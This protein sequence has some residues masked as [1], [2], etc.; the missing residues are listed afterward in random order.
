VVKVIVPAKVGVAELIPISKSTIK[1][2]S[3]L[4]IASEPDSSGR[5]V[6]REVVVFP[7]AARGTGEGS[8]P[9]DLPSKS[10]GHSRMT[11][12]TVTSSSAGAGHSKMTNGTVSASSVTGVTLTYH[13][14]SGSG[15]QSIVLPDTIPYVTF[16]PGSLKDLIVGAH[17]FVI[18]IKNSTN[19]NAVR[20]LVG[21]NGLVPPM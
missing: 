1:P 7:A 18:G 5:Q 19:F 4:G 16:L 13:A 11:N 12:G 3:F 10:G 20:V 8:Y 15:T 6:A 14:A 2:G 9:W 21:K 17:V